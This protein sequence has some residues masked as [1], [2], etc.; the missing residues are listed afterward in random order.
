MIVILTII[1]LFNPYVQSSDCN[2]SGICI[3]NELIVENFNT[4]SQ[5]WNLCLNNDNCNWFSYN[6]EIGDCLLFEKCPE[7]EQQ[8]D[9]ITSQVECDYSISK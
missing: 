8:G 2:I 1:I 9:F 5:C 7:L 6:W 3:N 4:I